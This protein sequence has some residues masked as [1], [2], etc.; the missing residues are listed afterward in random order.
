MPALCDVNFLVA[1]C[2]RAHQHHAKAKEWLDAGGGDAGLVL[3]RVSQLGM[4]RLLTNPAI[5]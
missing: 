4:L 1:M 3:C 2:H 5:M